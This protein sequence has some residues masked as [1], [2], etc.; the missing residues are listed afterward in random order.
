LFYVVAEVNCVTHAANSTVRDVFKQHKAFPVSS[1]IL[2][3]SVPSIH[4]HVTD[5][6]FTGVPKRAVGP[7]II[8]VSKARPGFTGKQEN[9]RM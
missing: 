6:S 9:M 8:S 4:F 1:V 2:D 3:R 5:L 7:K